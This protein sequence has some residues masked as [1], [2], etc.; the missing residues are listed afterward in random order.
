MRR[1][2][3]GPHNTLQQPFLP[4]PSLSE[5][6]R[7]FSA[8]AK[9]NTCVR[10]EHEDEHVVVGGRC[11]LSRSE[12]RLGTETHLGDDRSADR[13]ERDG[14]TRTILSSAKMSLLRNALLL[15][16]GAAL[17]SVRRRRRVRPFVRR[18]GH[19]LW[20]LTLPVLGG[21]RVMLPMYKVCLRV[22]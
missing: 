10:R 18:H 2:A 5:R 21:P 20:Q 22:W 12:L 4:L 3:E 9:D 1:G 14:R 15:L 19:F 16:R 17:P 7:R 6:P 13:A 8:M 11:E